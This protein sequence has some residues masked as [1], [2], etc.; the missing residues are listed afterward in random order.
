[1]LAVQRMLGN[2]TPTETLNTYTHLFDDGLGQVTA[3][4]SKM[5]NRHKKKKKPRKKMAEPV[6]V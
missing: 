2:A 3:S 5:L 4:I 6:P 1:M